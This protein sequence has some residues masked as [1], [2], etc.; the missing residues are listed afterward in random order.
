TG[1]QVG[2]VPTTLSGAEMTSLHRKIAG[3]ESGPSVRPVLVIAD[4]ALML[5]LPEPWLR[6]SAMNAFAHGVEALYGP[7]ADPVATPAARRG[8]ARGSVARCAGRR[9]GRLCRPPGPLPAAGAPRRHGPCRDDRRRPAADACADAR[10][11]AGRDGVARRGAR[12]GAGRPAAAG[13]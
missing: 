4:A 8:Q 1:A 7:R 11:R 3:R 10:P 13:R 12:G 2:A 9:P 5:S 6:M